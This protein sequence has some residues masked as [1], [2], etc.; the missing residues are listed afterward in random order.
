MKGSKKELETIKSYGD[1]KIYL[2][3]QYGIHNT[4]ELREAILK[5]KKFNAFMNCLG[6]KW[7]GDKTEEENK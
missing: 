3:Q 2:E 5:N 1:L 4:E 6:R 7:T